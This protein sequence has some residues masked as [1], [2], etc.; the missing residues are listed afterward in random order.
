MAFFP[1]L[2]VIF[3]LFSQLGVPVALTGVV[4]SMGCSGLAA[5]ALYRLGGPWAAVAWLF[6]PAAVFTVVPYTESLFVP[7]PSG[8]GR[9]HAPIAGWP[10]P[11]SRQSRAR[12]GVRAFPDR[13]AA[14]DDHH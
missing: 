5:A 7:P 2:P 6:A 14:G 10:P 13:R 3:W 11:R 4:L 9:E 12:P 8:P 1:G